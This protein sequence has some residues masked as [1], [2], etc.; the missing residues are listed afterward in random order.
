MA[1]PRTWR[2]YGDGYCLDRDEP[3]GQPAIRAYAQP[4]LNGDGWV[5]EVTAESKC[6]AIS[7]VRGHAEDRD[8]DRDG[9]RSHRCLRRGCAA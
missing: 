9:P 1:T 7:M 2:A 3:D 6:G 8:D 4:A 5:W